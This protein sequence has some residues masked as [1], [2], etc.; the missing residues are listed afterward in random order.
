MLI[1][2]CDKLV[3]TFGHD[4][5]DVDLTRNH[6]IEVLKS[7]LTTCQRAQSHLGVLLTRNKSIHDILEL[8][9][10]VC[11]TAHYRDLFEQKREERYLHLRRVSASMARVSAL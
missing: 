6:R 11:Q 7:A 5:V 9:V 10:C 1:S 3:E 8:I 4:I 2:V